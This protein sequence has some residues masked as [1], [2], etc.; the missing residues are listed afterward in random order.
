LFYVN[1]IATLTISNIAFPS[2]GHIP[3]DRKS[4]HVLS[5]TFG[6]I[7]LSG[8]FSMGDVHTEGAYRFYQMLARHVCAA[9]GGSPLLLDGFCWNHPDAHALY[10][11]DRPSRKHALVPAV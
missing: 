2:D 1:F 3:L 6:G 8:P 9:A 7:A 10:N 11:A 5:E 4:L